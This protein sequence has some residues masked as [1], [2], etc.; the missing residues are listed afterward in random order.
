MVEKAEKGTELVLGLASPDDFGAALRAARIILSAQDAELKYTAALNPSLLF[1][2]DAAFLGQAD[3]DLLPASA[4]ESLTACKQRVTASGKGESLDIAVGR[5]DRTQW[6]RVWVEP[7]SPNGKGVGVLSTCIDVTGEK[8][9]EEHLRLAL[10]ELAHRSKNLLAVVLSIAR[11]SAMKAR[12]SASSAIA[13]SAASS[14]WRLP[15]TC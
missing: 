2:E 7:L 4:S 1:A 6:F 12:R 14:L 5:A 15:M 11:Q 3:R 10:L 8:V 13:S 9:A